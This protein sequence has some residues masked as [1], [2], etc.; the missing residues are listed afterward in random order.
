MSACAKSVRL[1][2]QLQVKVLE[3][4][5]LVQQQQAKVEE[6]HLKLDPLL[7]EWMRLPKQWERLQAQ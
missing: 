7:A 2:D 6:E 3:D 5:R 1:V 4:L